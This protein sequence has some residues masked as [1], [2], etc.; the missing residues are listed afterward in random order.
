MRKQIWIKTV[1]SVLAGA[2]LCTSFAGCQKKAVTEN[3]ILDQ[4][5]NGTEYVQQEYSTIAES[6]KK[7]ETVYINAKPDG[8][9]YNVQVTDW[10]HTDTPQVRIQDVS[11]LSNI[12]NVKSLTEPIVK[13]DKLCW[14]MDLYYSG[15]TEAQP[16][17]T[18][19][20]K[21]F[22]DGKEL[23]AEEL[24]G[25]KGNVAIQITVNNSLKKKITVSGKTYEITCPMLFAGGTILP[26]ET[27]TNIA[28]DYG[29]AMSDGAKQLVFFTGIPGI[30]ESLGLSELNLSL[31]DEAMYTNTY[32]ITAYTECFALGNLMFAVIPF[33]SIG[34]FGNGGMADSIDNV[35]EILT[36]VEKIQPQ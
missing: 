7:E 34:A 27:F 11:N 35:K 36:D 10:L 13:D 20:I 3:Q 14:D 22:L 29:T 17:V 2:L 26:E 8:K 12:H 4:E 5:L 19:S 30:D 1:S 31:L 9:I 32:T 21:Y 15:T 28:I 33:S 25:K 24:A 18:V 23:S 16:P 6:A